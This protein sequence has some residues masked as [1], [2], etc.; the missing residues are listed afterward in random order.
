MP[1]RKT[2]ITT[3]KASANYLSYPTD[4]YLGRFWHT[5]KMDTDEWYKWL[6]NGDTFAYQHQ[7]GSFTVRCETRNGKGQFWS[8]FKKIDGKLKKV[9]IG[10]ADKLTYARLMEIKQFLDNTKNAV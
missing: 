4:T 7:G 5:V 1:N 2:A 10:T 9:Y 8:A 3:I 6:R